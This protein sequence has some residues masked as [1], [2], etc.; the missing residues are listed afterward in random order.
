MKKLA[1]LQHNLQ[2]SMCNRWYI[3]CDSIKKRILCLRLV[4]RKVKHCWMIWELPRE[5]EKSKCPKNSFF[6]PNKFNRDHSQGVWRNYFHFCLNCT[7]A[8][9]ASLFPQS[10]PYAIDTKPIISYQMLAKHCQN[11]K[12]W[13]GNQEPL[14]DEV[15]V[16]NKM[17]CSFDALSKW[18]SLH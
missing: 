17:P 16:K 5:S 2:H 9:I 14:N 7:V 10:F 8:T 6:L 3:Q 4:K 15:I 12:W 18:Q 11:D 1:Y 13:T